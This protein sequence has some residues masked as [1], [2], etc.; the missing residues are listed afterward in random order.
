MPQRALGQPGD[1]VAQPV[2]Q[3]GEQAAADVLPILGGAVQEAQRDQRGDGEIEDQ[4]H[5][6][7]Q[8]RDDREIADELADR[9]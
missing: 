6:G 3:P 9:P 1:P 4:G 8:R 7:R 5:D 2:D